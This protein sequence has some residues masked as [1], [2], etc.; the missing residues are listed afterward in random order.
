M[1]KGEFESLRAIYAS[2]PGFVPE[3]YTWG[4]YARRDPERWFLLA[5]FRDVGEQVWI[6]E[7]HNMSQP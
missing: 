3:P 1:C 2:S 4:R 7:S 6:P 5:E